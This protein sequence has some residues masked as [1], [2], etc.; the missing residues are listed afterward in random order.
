MMDQVNQSRADR[1]VN[2]NDGRDRGGVINVLHLQQ[3]HHAGG[4]TWLA[5]GIAADCG[6][7]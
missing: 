7:P 6:E 5:M 2:D 3:L 1:R 4:G